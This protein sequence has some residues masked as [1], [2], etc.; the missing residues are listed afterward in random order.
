MNVILIELLFYMITDLPW[1]IQGH[2]SHE[3]IIMFFQA[4]AN[5]SSTQRFQVKQV[6]HLLLGMIQEEGQ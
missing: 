2:L 5:K 3:H 6:G 4:N 1:L